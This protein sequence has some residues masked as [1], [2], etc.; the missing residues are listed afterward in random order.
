MSMMGKEEPSSRLEEPPAEPP[1]GAVAPDLPVPITQGTWRKAGAAAVGAA[2]F[3][4]WFGS[5]SPFVRQSVWHQLLFWGLCFGLVAVALYTVI[6]DLRYIR[7]QYAI[8]RRAAFEQTIGSEDFRKELLAAQRKP[9][10]NGKQRTPGG[11]PPRG[12]SSP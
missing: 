10:G 8:A 6:L 9:G 1:S 12:P 11:Q 2:A 3:L 4:A 7:L 5:D